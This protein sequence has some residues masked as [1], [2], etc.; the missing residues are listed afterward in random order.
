MGKFTLFYYPIY[1]FFT[2]MKI[3]RQ[4]RWDEQIYPEKQMDGKRTL[5]R[6]NR[7]SAGRT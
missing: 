2:L 6:R 7:Q 3:D 4:I 5:G 1:N